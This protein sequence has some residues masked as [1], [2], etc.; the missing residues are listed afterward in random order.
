MLNWQLFAWSVGF[1]APLAPGMESICHPCSN[2]E[3]SLKAPPRTA[4][5][6][7]RKKVH[8]HQHTVRLRSVVGRP[9]APSQACSTHS[10]YLLVPGGTW[11]CHLKTPSQSFL[12]QVKNTWGIFC[13]H[14]KQCT[15]SWD[16]WWE[17]RRRTRKRGSGLVHCQARQE[18]SSNCEA[19]QKI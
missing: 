16:L 12:K 17:A 3:I 2:H 4:Y 5:G 6:K 14:Y 15:R 19:T 10:Q 7:V 11:V 13:K 9:S 8:G 1:F 18:A